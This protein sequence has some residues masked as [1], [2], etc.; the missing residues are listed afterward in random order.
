MTGGG[1]GPPDIDVVIPTLD[2][3]PHL[4]LCLEGLSHQSYRGKINVIVVDGGSKDDTLGVATSFGAEI[5]ANPGQYATGLSGARHFGETRSRGEYVW[6]LDSDNLVT[7]RGVAASLAHPLLDDPSI[8]MSVPFL[9]LEAHAPSFNRW[10][11]RVEQS[12]IDAEVRRGRLEGAW[13]RVSPLQHG[14]SNGTLIRRSAL[15]AAGGYDSDVRL[16]QRLRRKG[17][18]TAALVE[19]AHIVH[20]QVDSLGD[21]VRKSRS[22]LRRFAGMSDGE[23]RSYF[24]EYP[25]PPE[26]DRELHRGVTRSLL[27]RPVQ[28]IQ[29][30]QRTGDPAWLWGTVYPLVVLGLVARHPMA[31]WRVYRRFL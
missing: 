19:R 8:Q 7:D 14:I 27:D 11:A 16:L 13:V 29:G 2:C 28:A 4:A 23:L 12:A 3:A 15:T 30:Y 22:R 10:L 20:A 9:N 31:S 5:H 25:V 6:L 1:S 21:F 26:I 18:A 17:L 24:C